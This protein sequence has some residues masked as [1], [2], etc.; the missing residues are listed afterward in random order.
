MLEKRI[1]Y[2]DILKKYL[3]E[4]SLDLVTEWIIHYKVHLKIKKDRASKLG[5]YRHPYKDSGHIITINTGLNPYSFLITL[6]HE[7]AHLVCWEKYKRKIKP[8]GEEWKTEYMQLMKHFTHQ[9]IFP[10]DIL[11]AIHKHLNNPMASSC[12][13]IELLRVLNKYDTKTEI[14]YLENIPENAVFK[15]ST[16]RMFR[17][18]KRLRKRYQCI[19]L[20]NKR[21]Y[22][23][24]PMADVMMVED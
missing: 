5:D 13:D 22:L 19:D 4:N 11:K 15:L 24:S 21:T 6:I 9:H 1:I 8:H 2:K 3:P 18:G 20:Q 23:V 12:A 17:K 7:I 14:I 10:D 16:G